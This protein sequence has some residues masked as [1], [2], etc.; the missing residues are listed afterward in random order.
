MLI[1]SAQEIA[2]TFIFSF[3]RIYRIF[4]LELIMLI[5]SIPGKCLSLL[6]LGVGILLHLHPEGQAHVL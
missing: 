6:L 2:Q 4:I 5:L 1:L 3:D